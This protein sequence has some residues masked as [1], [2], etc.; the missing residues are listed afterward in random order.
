[1][2]AILETEERC[3]R[4][5]ESKRNC[6]DHIPQKLPYVSLEIVRA[7]EVVLGSMRTHECDQKVLQTCVHDQ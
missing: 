2:R 5:T 7:V 6:W 3:V 4:V 1:M